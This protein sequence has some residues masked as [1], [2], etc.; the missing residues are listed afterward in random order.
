MLFRQ[1]STA[2]I[3]PF[4]I[5]ALLLIISFAHAGGGKPSQYPVAMRSF[6][7]WEPGTGERFDFSVWYPG[8]SNFL[9]DIRIKDGWEVS[10]NRP[11]RIIPGFYPVILVS[12]DAA[13]SRYAN[14]DLASFLASGGFIVIV[15]T[16]NGDSQNNGSAMYSAQIFRD[17]P[18]QMLRALETLLENPDF[19]YFMDESRIG[20]LGIGFGSVT[21]LQLAGASPDIS[22][23]DDYCSQDRSRD[24]FCGGWPLQRLRRATQDMPIL[25]RREGKRLFAPPLTLYAPKLTQAKLSKEVIAL[26][27]KQKEPEKNNPQTVW[28]YLFGEDPEDNEPAEKENGAETGTSA[29]DMADPFPLEMDF[30]GGPLFGGA[31]AGSANIQP[32]APDSPEFRAGAEEAPANIPDAAVAP[33]AESDT[34]TVFRRPPDTRRIR[35]VALMSPAGGMLF[36][37]EQLH[38]VRV[39]VVMVQAG[40]NIL[41]PPEGHAQPYYAGLPAPPQVL[42]LDEADHFS[43]FARCSDE[44][45][46]VL[47]EQCGRTKED[48][49]EKNLRERNNFLLNFFQTS[50]GLPLAP[51]LPP[52]FVAIPKPQPQG[53]RER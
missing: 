12:H 37:P 35:G 21:A 52:G 9:E 48:Q 15:P 20:V 7:V 32:P 49:R 50:V 51:T 31:V 43:L 16:H 26:F 44:S 29:S 6:G 53:N 28:H 24:A 34:S 1:R 47:S 11:G 41:Y 4:L 38:P 18:R 42:R 5:C 14:N 2:Y 36:T 27:E 8:G 25:E 40:K 10:H 30:Q 13:G 46:D 39:P 19:T 33:E 17:R 22:Y 3:F 45:K 23:I